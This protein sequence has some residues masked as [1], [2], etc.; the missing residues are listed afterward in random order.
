MHFH[1][2]VI[3][4]QIDTWNV[5]RYFCTNMKKKSRDNSKLFVNVY[6]K[7]TKYERVSALKSHYQ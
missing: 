4:K 1:G 2:L 3:E 5:S 6:P 7:T